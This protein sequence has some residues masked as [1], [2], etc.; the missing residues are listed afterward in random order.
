MALG[1]CTLKYLGTIQNTCYKDQSANLS[2][3]LMI[4]QE[5]AYEA[6]GT[7]LTT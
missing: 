6:F 4:E 7:E 2:L 5:L 1:E 3:H